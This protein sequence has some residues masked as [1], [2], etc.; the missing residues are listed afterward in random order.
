MRWLGSRLFGV[1]VLLV[2][3]V[4]VIRWAVETLMPFWP[5]LAL[6]AV[7]VLAGRGLFLSRRRRW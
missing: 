2:I 1:L 3:A 6:V 4:L 7:V 5:L